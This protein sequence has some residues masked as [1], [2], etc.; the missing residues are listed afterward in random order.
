MTYP[1]SSCSK[2]KVSA[3][4][5]SVSRFGITMIAS[6]GYFDRFIREHLKYRVKKYQGI[7]IPGK[8]EMLISPNSGYATYGCWRTFQIDRYI[9]N[10]Q[11]EYA[12]VSR[13]RFVDRFESIFITLRKW[14]TCARHTLTQAWPLSANSLETESIYSQLDVIEKESEEKS[15]RFEAANRT[16]SFHVESDNA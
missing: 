16:G 1:K 2:F 6:F 9:R 13:A 8:G 5:K 12:A 7:P 4:L 11:S 3:R 15:K 14:A 10:D